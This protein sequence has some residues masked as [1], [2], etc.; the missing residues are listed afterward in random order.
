MKEAEKVS[1]GLFVLVVVITVGGFWMFSRVM[2]SRLRV[3][4]EQEMAEMHARAAADDAAKNAFETEKEAAKK[5]TA[6]PCTEMP[7]EI[8]Q[9]IGSDSSKTS[10]VIMGYEMS[11]LDGTKP[12]IRPTKD[13]GV[14]YLF[15]AVSGEQI[16]RKQLP[17]S[18]PR[19]RG[20][21]R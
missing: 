1:P 14:E 3:A 15:T 5:R 7:E 12:V 16:H 10:V 13:G 4:H 6:D 20:G 17:R 19:C 21:A 11:M 9:P 8:I 2:T 18:S